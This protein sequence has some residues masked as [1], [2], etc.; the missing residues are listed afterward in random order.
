MRSPSP[1]ARRRLWPI[2]V[3]TGILIVLA[4][5]WTGVWFYAASA[6][7]TAL[8]GW[9]A[10]EAKSGRI[11][12][13]AQQTIGGFPFRIEVRCTEPKAE[14]RADGMPIA[15]N[16]ADLVVLAQVYQPTLLIGEFKGPAGVGDPG[17]PPSYIANWRVGQA[18]VRG[19]PRAPQRVSIVFDDP[20]VQRAGEGAAILAAKRIEL[21]GRMLEGSATSNPVIELGLRSTAATVPELH[22]MAKT[23]IDSEIAFVVRGLADFGPKPWPARFRELHQRDGSI[24]ITRARAQQ[25]DIVAVSTGT[26]KLNERGNLDGQLQ[27]TV[28]NIEQLIRALDLETVAT[29]GRVG[30]TFD[31][32]DRILP[33]LADVA[34]KNVTPGVLAAVKAVGKRATLEG[35][36]ATTVPLRFMD[37]RISLGP[38]PVG[39]VPPLF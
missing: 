3:P 23:P 18:S 14:L 28:I 17:K 19:T 37:G 32:L 2:F 4:A 12:E 39:R 15:L 33:G 6:A 30:E 22:A 16:A 36:Q 24:E 7:E 26:L 35:K 13:C 11:Y 27:L 21:H 34:R 9:R 25:G 29:K 5:I 20:S 1:P 8:A 31:K 38:I 10:R